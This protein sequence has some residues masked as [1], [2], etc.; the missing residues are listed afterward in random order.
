[1]EQHVISSHE[2]SHFF[3]QVNGRPQTTQIFEG[4]LDLF[5]F[6]STL[7]FPPRRPNNTRVGTAN[8]Q[9]RDCEKTGVTNA[10]LGA[11]KA[12]KTMAQRGIAHLKD[13]ALD[14]R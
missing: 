6:F 8:E 1:L 3:L 7:P 14:K 13:G 10:V 2:R 4:R 5:G 9:E 11:V 12:K